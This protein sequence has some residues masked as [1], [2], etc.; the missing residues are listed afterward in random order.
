MFEFAL[1]KKYLSF[2]KSQLSVSLI[3]LM[4]ILVI[5]VVVWL[6]LVFLSVTEGIERNWTQK[7]TAL[8]GPIRIQPTENYFSSYYYQID[9]YAQESNYSFKNIRQKAVSPHPDPYDYERDEELPSSFPKPQKEQNGSLKDPV[10]K[11][12][13]ILEQLQKKISGFAF[14]D[15]E[16]SGA[17]LRLQISTDAISHQFLTQVSYLVSFTDQNPNIQSLLIHPQ[18]KELN[19]LLSLSF[20]KGD[21]V[22]ED[23]PK[24]EERTTFSNLLSILNNICIEEMQTNLHVWKLPASLIP[25]QGF[26]NATAS[27]QQGQITH[28]IVHKTPTG[29]GQFEIKQNSFYFNGQKIPRT[30]PIFIEGPLH[31]QTTLV[32]DS[33]DKAHTL[34]DVRFCA[35]T[36]VQKQPLEG[37]IP[38][39]GLEIVKASIQNQFDTIPKDLPP[40]PYFLKKKAVMLPKTAQGILPIFLARSFQENGVKLGDRGYLSYPSMTTSGMQEQ[41]CAVSV[42]GFYDG[43]IMAMSSKYILV[44]SQ[45]TTL[46]NASNSP[47]NIDKM[48]TNGIALWFTESMQ[49]EKI[50]EE[51]RKAFQEAGIDS[52]W[53]ITTYKE[54]DFAKDLLQ[55]F[56]SDKYLFTLIGVIVLAVACSNII[57]MLILLVQ[58]KKRE[59]GILQAMGASKNS[60]ALIFGL[61]GVCIGMISSLIGIALALLTLHNID[62]VVKILSLL[63]G[64][65]AFNT[66]FFGQSLPDTLSHRALCFVLIATPLI[67]L[68]AGLIPAIKACRLQPSQILRSE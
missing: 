23:V 34:S 31:F 45:I 28:L 14:Q 19:H 44:P 21:H 9:Q 50:K 65:E 10:K 41:R 29:K 35:K 37:E 64:H 61:C 51:L 22:C 33:L 5:S 36:M 17:L 24:E 32:K 63:Q 55:Q 3:S 66:L 27:L 30:T 26:F 39:A 62:F 67:S 53:K 6:V 56:Q 4:S 49:C 54:Y 52:Y 42:A 43:G 13:Q 58:N 8:N 25:E 57:S 7:L 12:Y 68:L 38:W 48:A 40:W 2:K 60:I 59:I 1:V 15:Y 11:A 47:Y 18:A 20:R 16:L 46:I